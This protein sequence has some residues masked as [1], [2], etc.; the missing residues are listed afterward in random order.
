MTYSSLL[1]RQRL[2]AHQGEVV[3][4]AAPIVVARIATASGR[5]FQT[6]AIGNV[7]K[8][9]GEIVSERQPLL[10][11]LNILQSRRQPSSL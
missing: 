2:G 8:P 6:I 11:P 1:V 10:S 3:I 9:D 5:M 7:L 4:R